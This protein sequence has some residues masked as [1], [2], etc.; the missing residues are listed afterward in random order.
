MPQKEGTL[1]GASAHLLPLQLL[2]FADELDQQPC[3]LQVMAEFLPVFQLFLHGACLLI[4]LPL[5]KARTKG[6]WSPP[7]PQ[8]P[9]NGFSNWEACLPPAL[10]LPK[11]LPPSTTQ[12]LCPRLPGAKVPLQHCT[13][14]N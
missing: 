8:F 1:E 14:P 13:T 9:S 3:S 6:L 5:N 2:P 4:L 7:L 11:V 12:G 10:R